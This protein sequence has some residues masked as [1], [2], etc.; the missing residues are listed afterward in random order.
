M[1]TFYLSASN[2][3]SRMA[4]SRNRKEAIKEADQLCECIHHRI[5]LL[6]SNFKVIYFVEIAKSK[7]G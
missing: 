4:N 1:N 3:Y 2:G 6:D 7:K 5:N